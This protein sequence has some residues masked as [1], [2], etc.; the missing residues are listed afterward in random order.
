MNH[1][2]AHCTGEITTHY[3]CPQKDTCIRYLAHL[4]ALKHR[5]KYPLTYTSAYVCSQPEYSIAGHV[6]HKQPFNEY[7]SST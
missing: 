3:F 2:I 7:V 5:Y 4:D 1:D 6:Y